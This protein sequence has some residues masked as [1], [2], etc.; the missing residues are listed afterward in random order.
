MESRRGFNL[1]ISI[2]PSCF[3]VRYTFHIV[4]SLCEHTVGQRMFS[5]ITLN[6]RKY[7]LHYSAVICTKTVT[8][9]T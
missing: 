6:A 7:H 1:V 9:F 3:V 2:F 8:M 5:N 4:V